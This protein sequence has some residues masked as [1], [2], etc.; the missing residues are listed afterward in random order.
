M[1]K[2]KPILVGLLFVIAISLENC[3]PVII[4]SRPSRPTPPW[5][6]PH[7]VVNV[8]YVYFPDF[9]IYYDLT[10]RHYIYFENGTWLSVDVL[11]QRFNTRNFRNSR[12]VLIKNYF[13]D[14]I[15]EYHQRN[16]Y[17]RGRRGTRNN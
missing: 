15:R 8:R 1:K 17:V 5:F 16:T 4:S 10:L 13:G 6:Y 12:Q 7:R 11:P 9:S 14:N 3:G 2:L